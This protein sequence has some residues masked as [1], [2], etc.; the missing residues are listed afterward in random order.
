MQIQLM[1]NI[2]DKNVVDK[3]LTTV[4]TIE[5]NLKESTDILDPVLTLGDITPYI[6]KFNYVYIPLLGRYYFIMDVKSIRSDLWQI[7]CHVDVLQTYKA[8]IRNNS[9]LIARQQYN[10]N[11]MQSDPRLRVNANP[12]IVTK[13]F[14]KGFNGSYTY[15]LVVSG[16]T[17]DD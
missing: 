16:N 17:Y 12:Y 2:S 3:K 11:V 15:A 8:Q 1:S 13:K 4:A 14:P 7:S 6:N 9:G 5:G 10:Y